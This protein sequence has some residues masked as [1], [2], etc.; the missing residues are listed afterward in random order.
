MKNQLRFVLGL[1][2][3]LIVIIFALQN[4]QAVVVNFFGLQ[5]QWP[6]IIIIVVAL[7]LGAGITLLLSA[8]SISAARKNSKRLQT[9]LN[10]LRGP[11]S[12][13][14]AKEQD[15]QNKDNAKK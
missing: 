3:A 11:K 2:L 9:E 14:K 5:L 10:Q 15:K 13:I 8:A 6:M 12:V 1:V 7:L 4:S